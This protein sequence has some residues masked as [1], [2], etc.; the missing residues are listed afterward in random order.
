MSAA[1]LIVFGPGAGIARAQQPPSSPLQV[2][3]AVAIADAKIAEE[4]AHNTD[5]EGRV[6][7]FILYGGYV[8]NALDPGPQTE[9][10][11]KTAYARL[12]VTDPRLA[13][14][15]PGSG[16]GV[17]KA[18]A[19]ALQQVQLAAKA[20]GASDMVKMHAMHV[21]TSLENVRNGP[22][23]P[24][25]WPSKILCREDGVGRPAIRHRARESR[26]ANQPGIR[27]E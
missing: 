14:P 24:S 7:D 16:T 13:N 5:L 10:L 27:C 3:M 4:H 11:V 25:S 9:A 2:Q 20:E 23:R 19:G 18:V 6:N 15:L 17:K 26:Y 8:L 1:V 22:I 12:P 21:S